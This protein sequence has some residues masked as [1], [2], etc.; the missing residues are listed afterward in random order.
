[1]ADRKL[2]AQIESEITAQ[3]KHAVQ[4]ALDAPFPSRE[5]VDQDVYA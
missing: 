3:T 5:E 4:S 1:M 2:L